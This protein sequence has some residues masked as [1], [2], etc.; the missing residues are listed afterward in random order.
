MVPYI[1]PY[2]TVAKVPPVQA[3]MATKLLRSQLACMC[4][5]RLALEPWDLKW[6]HLVPPWRILKYYQSWL[7]PLPSLYPP[8]L[9]AC[10]SFWQNTTVA[11]A[12]ATTKAYCL[13]TIKHD[14]NRHRQTQQSQFWSQQLTT[15]ALLQDPT[16]QQDR[17]NDGQGLSDQAK[18]ANI[19]MRDGHETQPGVKLEAERC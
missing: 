3:N 6:Q 14:Q 7:C 4:L 1:H 2:L 11:T 12:T 16:G 15:L 17:E 10:A 8:Q 9:N 13:R 5:V 18:G 19:Q